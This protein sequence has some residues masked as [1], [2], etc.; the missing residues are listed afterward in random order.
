MFRFQVFLP[1]TLV[2][3][4]TIKTAPPAELVFYNLPRPVRHNPASQS[5]P[6]RILGATQEEPDQDLPRPTAEV[7]DGDTSAGVKRAP[8]EES[9]EKSVLDNGDKRIK[10][11]HIAPP[12]IPAW[13][14]S[15]HNVEA[16]R[17]LG[18][19]RSA[20]FART[21]GK[22]LRY[23]ANDRWLSDNYARTRHYRVLLLAEYDR[24]H[25][26]VFPASSS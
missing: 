23:A 11:D 15:K 5:L 24:N 13:G 10:L 17:T 22:F 26:P 1:P 16:S 18:P 14:K 6:Q 2:P 8:E 20:R 21:S 12:A 25:H 3:L 19:R 7:S 9:W 4:E